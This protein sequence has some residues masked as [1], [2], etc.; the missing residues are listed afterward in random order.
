MAAIDLV[1]IAVGDIAANFQ[2]SHTTVK[3]KLQNIHHILH[4]HF[5][6]GKQA[7]TVPKL[8]IWAV[9]HEQIG[10]SRYGRAKKSRASSPSQ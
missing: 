9:Q 3:H 4:L 6:D 10:K 2:G 8:G 1:V 7:A 5:Y